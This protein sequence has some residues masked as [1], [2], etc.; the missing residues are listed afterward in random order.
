MSIYQSFFD[1]MALGFFL[2]FLAFYLLY[3]YKTQRARKPK[4]DIDRLVE[5][6]KRYYRGVSERKRDEFE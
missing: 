4:N 3:R 5:D 6:I 1:G 2:G